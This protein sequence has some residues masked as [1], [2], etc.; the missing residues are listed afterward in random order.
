M[1]ESNNNYM[2]YGVA[3]RR[4]DFSFRER[5]S[6]RQ[7]NVNAAEAKPHGGNNQLNLQLQPASSMSRLTTLSI[8]RSSS[9]GVP[10]LSMTISAYL[11]FSA[12]GSCAL[13]RAEASSRE[14]LSRFM[15]RCS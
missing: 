10:E 12:I 14:E 15:R 3:Y 7:P 11:T 13:R 5:R 4:R 2:W 1:R 9:C 8:W 6:A